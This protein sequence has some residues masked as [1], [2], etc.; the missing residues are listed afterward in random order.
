MKRDFLKELGIEDKTTIDKI[1]DENSK[2]IGRAKSEVDD[3]ETK[4]ADLTAQL[5][6]KTQEYDALKESTKD[7]ETIKGTIKQLELDKAQLTTDNA[8]L[9]VDLDTKLQEMQKTHDREN[10]V[11]DA[12]AK[13]VKAV[14]ALL[15]PDKDTDEQLNA[16]KAAEDTAFLFG[17]TY[18]NSPSG[19][20]LNNPPFNGGT[21]GNPPVG[22]T[23][24][25]AIA[26]KFN[27]NK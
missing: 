26:A 14:M 5:A 24:G 13:N 25:E 19:T 20:Q 1:L 3:L 15:D 8:Q 12:K 2:D 23:L 22:K 18:P 6:S 27:S 21:G 11:R 10:K 7:Y 17:E 16:L 9:Q 4:N